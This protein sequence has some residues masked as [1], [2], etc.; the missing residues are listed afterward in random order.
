MFW[1]SEFELELVIEVFYCEFMIIMVVKGNFCFE[2]CV[3]FG[4]DE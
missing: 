3:K 1:G 2:I 4:F